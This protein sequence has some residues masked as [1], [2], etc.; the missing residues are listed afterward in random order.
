[1]THQIRVFTFKEG[2]LSRIAHD[3]RL[4]VERFSIEGE[5]G[6]VVAELEPGSIVVD[7][8]M[9]GARFDPSGLG[10]SDRAKVGETMR[11]KVLETRRHPKIT[12]RGAVTERE[13]ERVE[14]EGELE[15][16]GVRRP[17]SFTAERAGDRG[18]ER[19]TARVTL[20]PTDHG[21]KPYKALAGAIRLQDRV[22][23]ELDLDAAA[24]G[25]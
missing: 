10:A 22:V 8:V 1:M 13:A 5:D 23:V 3:L 20:R 6:R 14:V 4:H 9:D 25:L 18:G 17:L 7:G 2:L 11:T 21:I 15:L 16:H 24:L 12:F 19:V